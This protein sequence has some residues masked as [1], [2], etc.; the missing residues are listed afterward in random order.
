MDQE[1]VVPDGDFQ[2][3]IFH[4]IRPIV[5]EELTKLHPLAQKHDILVYQPFFLFTMIQMEHL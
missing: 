5:L 1:N 4:L 2:Q 3:L